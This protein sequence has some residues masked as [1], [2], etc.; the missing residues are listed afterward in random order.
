MLAV[1]S[2]D[3]IG[4]YRRFRRAGIGCRLEGSGG[5]PPP[6]WISGFQGELLHQSRLALA[7][8][9]LES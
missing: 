5:I 7:M 6:L 8:T 4:L 3:F 1:N 9:P 2:W